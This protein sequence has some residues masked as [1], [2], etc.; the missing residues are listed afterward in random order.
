MAIQEG[1][2]QDIDGKATGIFTTQV[3]P[4]R[5]WSKEERSDVLFRSL[6]REALDIE[7]KEKSGLLP[8]VDHPLAAI[9]VA[10]ALMEDKPEC[11]KKLP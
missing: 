7:L 10:S 2:C 4:R 8:T 3:W 11:T 9:A 6:G 5:D 1:P